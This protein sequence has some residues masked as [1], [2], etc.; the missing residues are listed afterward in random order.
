M[1]IKNEHR[2]LG[3]SK[4]GPLI[5]IVLVGGTISAVVRE[6]PLAGLII[7]GVLFLGWKGYE[8]LVLEAKSDDPVEDKIEDHRILK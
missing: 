8:V 3:A 5:V 6:F 1:S 2:H 4:I 7:G